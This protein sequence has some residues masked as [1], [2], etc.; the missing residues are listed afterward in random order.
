MMVI[1]VS[2]EFCFVCL[3]TAFK[4][5]RHRHFFSLQLLKFSKILQTEGAHAQKSHSGPFVSSLRNQPQM[6]A[7]QKGH[8]KP[9]N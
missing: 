5:I 7:L 4:R 8:A 3:D 1:N 6:H 9:S 2:K